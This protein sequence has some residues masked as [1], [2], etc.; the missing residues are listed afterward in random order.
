MGQAKQKKL[1][2]ST[3]DAQIV[4]GV[5]AAI[6]KL[7][8]AASGHLGRDCYLHALLGRELL[9]DFGVETEVAAGFAAWRVGESDGSVVA[10][11]NKVLG[12]LPEGV[13]GFAYHAWLKC[14]S[15]IIDFTTYQ[16]P[17]K[18]ADLDALDGGKTDIE[19]APSMLVADVRDVRSYK[20]VAQGHAGMFYYERD[21]RSERILADTSGLDIEDVER[22]RVIFRNPHL[23]VLGP[24]DIPC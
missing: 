15:K 12:F 3:L 1:R 2:A 18:A 16:L 17:Q 11:T 19:W 13:P 20:E 24:N 23:H 21:A 5:G 14:S 9:K 6:R 8:Q 22:A 4:E 7:A 10:H